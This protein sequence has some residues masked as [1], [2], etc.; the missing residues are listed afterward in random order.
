DERGLGL[1]EAAE[2][3]HEHRVVLLAGHASDGQDD[4]RS[5]VEAALGGQTG[6]G[7]G[8]RLGADGFDLWG[9]GRQE[10][11]IIGAEALR[12]VDEVGAGAEDEVGAAGEH[13]LHPGLDLRS[14]ALPAGPVVEAEDEAR[15]SAQSPQCEQGDE[16][17]A[18]PVG[19]DDLG[20]EAA[21]Q[22]ALAPD[23]GGI[24]DADAGAELE[25]GEADT[26]QQGEAE[27]LVGG[28]GADDPDLVTGRGH[29]PGQG[30]DVGADSPGGGA[31][32]VDDPHDSSSLSSRMVSSSGDWA[33]V[34]G[35]WPCVSAPAARS[36]PGPVA[37]GGGSSAELSLRSASSRRISPRKPRSAT[38]T[39]T[40]KTTHPR[41]AA[42]PPAI[43]APLPP[44]S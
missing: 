41:S 37:T 42:P 24:A 32:C 30:P 15:A 28:C 29:V 36:P 21:Q 16:S 23:Q 22:A 12:P 38:T 19:V 18:E 9:R 35:D 10:A 39:M 11:R 4:D 7:G 3:A 40:A 31:E 13:R 1:A 2:G 20:V 25:A 27:V 44:L 6:T 14:Q 26:G 43:T 8:G 34:S 17:G 5:F 33:C